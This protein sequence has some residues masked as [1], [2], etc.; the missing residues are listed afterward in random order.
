MWL[1]DERPAPAGWLA[2]RWPEE[3]IERLRSNTVTHISLDHDLGD[4]ARGTGYDVIV[5]IEQ[6]MRRNGFRPPPI[7]IHSA[8]PAARARMVAGVAAIVRY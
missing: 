1:D 6:E 7:A 4:D 5:W 8:N 3:A 2:V